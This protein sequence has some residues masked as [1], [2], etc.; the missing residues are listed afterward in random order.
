MVNHSPGRSVL[1]PAGPRRRVIFWRHGRTS[2]NAAGRFQGQSDIPWMTLAPLRRAEQR[3]YSPVNWVLPAMQ[4]TL[5]G[6][7]PRICP[8][9]TPLHRN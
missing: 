7:F 4:N 6:S 9:P 5:C 8:A 1:Q 2:W 3:P